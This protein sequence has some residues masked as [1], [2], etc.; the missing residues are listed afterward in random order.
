M[1]RRELI[2]RI[3]IGGAGYILLPYIFGSCEKQEDSGFSPFQI[4]LTSPGNAALNNTNGFI[5]VN[6]VIVINTGNDNFIALSAICTHQSCTVSFNPSTGNLPC[7]C[8]G[9]VYAQNGTVLNG[10]A[11]RALTEYT[12]T[13]E[14][15]IL[16]VT[17]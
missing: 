6:N 7:P 3:T 15:D 4:D 10:P 13:K 17:E 14:G 2:K 12:V 9:S 8:H 5:V 1:I 11:T 16:N